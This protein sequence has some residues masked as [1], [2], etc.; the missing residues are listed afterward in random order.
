MLYQLIVTCVVLLL[1]FLASKPINSA[2]FD[3]TIKWCLYAIATLIAIA[4][5]GS[6]WGLHLG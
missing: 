6:V 1:W 3:A 5:I 2:P 4:V